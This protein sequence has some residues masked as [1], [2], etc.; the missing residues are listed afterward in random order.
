[1]RPRRG[2][3]P[4]LR[5]LAIAAVFAAFGGG[6]ALGSAGGDDEG[7]GTVAETTGAPDGDDGE[8]QVRTDDGERYAGSYTL[9]INI[10]G[11]GEGSVFAAG[12]ECAEPV[13]KLEL[14]AGTEVQFDRKEGDK[15]TF[16]G[17]SGACSEFAC[18][19]TM[20][21]PMSVTAS[22][23]PEETEVTEKEGEE[24]DE[25]EETGEEGGLT[26]PEVE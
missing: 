17:Y 18:S 16:A 3:S 6:L 20:T 7:Q 4:A 26:T 15:S 10:V 19:L 2:R 24:V 25:G 23:E 22:F 14:P 1:M 9:V 21:A 8:S 11:D 13:C 12:S 5:L